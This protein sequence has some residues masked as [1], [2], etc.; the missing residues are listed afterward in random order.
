[1]TQRIVDLDALAGPPRQV[2]LGG[3]LWS[4]P[5]D[6]PAPLYVKL[7]HIGEL[8]ER[9][10]DPSSLDLTDLY[11]RMLALFQVHHPDVDE[12]PIGL[13]Q[14]M[15]AIGALYGDGGDEEAAPPTPAK[16]KPRTTAKPNRSRS[17]RS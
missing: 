5:A 4:L 11:D 2:K 10:E 1:M 16:A 8:S 9:N 13:Q 14:L 6:I 7:L 15:E 3:E 17:S 12:L